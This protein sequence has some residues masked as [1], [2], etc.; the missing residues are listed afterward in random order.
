MRSAIVCGSG[1]AGL[2]AAIA[3]SMKGWSV[4]VYERSS[5]VREIGAGIFIKANGLRVLQKLEVLDRIRRD[6]VVLREART[7]SKDGEA[8][9]RRRLHELN[10]VWTIQRQH[11]IRAFY[12]RAVQLGVQV[13]TDCPVASFDPEGRVTIKGQSLQAELVIAADGVNSIARRSLGLD[14]P[15]R[16]P[17]SGAI[18]FLIPR[19]APEVEDVVREFWSGPLRVGVAPCTP[20]EAFSYLIAPLADARGKRTPVDTEYWASQFPKLASEG[21]FERAKGA[22]T[23]HHPYP[24]AS[25]RSWFIGRI[26]LVG[27]AAHALPPTLGQGAGLSL[28]NTLLLSDYL[29]EKSDTS[30]ALAAWQRDWRWI[31]DR[32]QSWSRRYDRVTS[33]WPSGLYFLRDAVIWSIGK[34]RRFNG[35]MRIADRV[36]AP[37]RRVLPVRPISVSSGVRAHEGEGAS[38]FGDDNGR[39]EEIPPKTPSGAIVSPHRGALSN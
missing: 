37:A 32:T 14:R 1:V 7:L 22:A 33:E 16:S 19:E 21:L 11:L 18:R 27:D 15:V 24:F 12:D 4:D 5:T 36:D 8:L 6:C 9:Q 29:S 31:S 23:V 10:P 20:T 28:T 13:H 26:A 25:A 39:H 17:R 34:S 30:A 3:L 35:Y 2:S 38:R